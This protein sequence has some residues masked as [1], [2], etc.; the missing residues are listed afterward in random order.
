[1]QA[2]QVQKSWAEIY[3]ANMARLEIW[4]RELAAKR[5]AETEE[6]RIAAV[7][8][9]ALCQGIYRVGRRL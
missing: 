4:K 2:N 1:M 7:G 9:F 3:E 8:R 6:D 5:E